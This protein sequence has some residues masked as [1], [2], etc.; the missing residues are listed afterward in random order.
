MKTHRI[1]EGDPKYTN[2]GLWLDSIVS[3][4][5]E[6]TSKIG[7]VTCL[8]CLGKGNA[9]GKSKSKVKAKT[10]KKKRVA[11]PDKPF[12]DLSPEKEVAAEQA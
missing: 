6:A 3:V 11:K 9:G 12:V 8:R 5:P 1:F 10:P 7:D 4:P 2:C